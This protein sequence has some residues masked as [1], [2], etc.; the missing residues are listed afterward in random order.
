MED[1]DTCSKGEVNSAAQR[2]E[3]AEVVQPDHG[4]LLR[5]LHL[6]QDRAQRHTEECRIRVEGALKRESWAKFAFK[7][8]PPAWVTHS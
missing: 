4:P 7:L 5:R 3:R 8:R 2:L 1:R 6:K